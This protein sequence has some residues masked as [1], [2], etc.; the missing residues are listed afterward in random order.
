MM[1]AEIILHGDEVDVVEAAL[2][3]ESRQAL[4]RARVVI[5]RL[6]DALRIAVE[7]QDTVSLRAALN[8]YLRWAAVASQVKETL[9]H[10]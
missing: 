8:S 9:D 2:R 7:A 6:D 3:P 5:D 1:R 4:P 10:G